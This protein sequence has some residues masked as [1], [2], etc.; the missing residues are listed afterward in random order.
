MTFKRVQGLFGSLS[1]LAKIIP[2]TDFTISNNVLY[3]I[4]LATN[5][6]EKFFHYL[7]HVATMFEK[8]NL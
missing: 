7:N 6:R 1:I 3:L 5:L 4:A 2:R 8:K